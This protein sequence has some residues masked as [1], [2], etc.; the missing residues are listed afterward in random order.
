MLFFSAIVQL[1]L[2]NFDSSWISLNENL[3]FRH[4]V[5]WWFSNYSDWFREFIQWV[6]SNDSLKEPAHSSHFV[7]SVASLFM[8]ANFYY[9]TLLYTPFTHHRLETHKK[10]FAITKLDSS[11]TGNNG[12]LLRTLP[13]LMDR[14]RYSLLLVKYNVRNR[15]LTPTIFAV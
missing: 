15:I 11:G 12:L 9:F 8:G 13:S 1:Q 7:W 2:I 5:R 6:Y 4:W 14:W 3:Q 10:S